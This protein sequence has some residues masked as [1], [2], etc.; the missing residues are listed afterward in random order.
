MRSRIRG[1]MRVNQGRIGRI[2]GT[3][4]S[5]P[6]WRRKKRFSILAREPSSTRSELSHSAVRNSRTER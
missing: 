2:V 1:S 4:T 3:T 6:Y 5:I